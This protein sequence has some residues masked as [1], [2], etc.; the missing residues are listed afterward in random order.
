MTKEVCAFNVLQNNGY[1]RYSKSNFKK[2]IRDTNGKIIL[3]KDD[4]PMCFIE[5]EMIRFKTELKGIAKELKKNLE[6]QGYTVTYETNRRYRCYKEDDIWN[7]LRIPDVENF[8]IV[9]CPYD[10]EEVIFEM[11]KENDNLNSKTKILYEYVDGQ[12]TRL[13]RITN[14]SV[15]NKRRNQEQKRTE[16]A[17]ELMEKLFK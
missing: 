3:D 1:I 7:S 5:M 9:E 15:K 2:Y 8:T 14:D 13:I 12:R 4:S 16:E 10:I 17:I 6:K 11:I